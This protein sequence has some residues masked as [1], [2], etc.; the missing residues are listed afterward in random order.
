MLEDFQDEAREACED[1]Y[2][3]LR[4]AC[5]HVPQLLTRAGRLYERFLRLR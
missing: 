2:E 3:I 5:E 1:L 4:Q